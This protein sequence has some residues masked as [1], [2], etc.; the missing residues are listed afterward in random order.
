M[1]DNDDIFG[2]DSPEVPL[3]R[4]NLEK[5]KFSKGDS[6]KFSNTTFHIY[7][8]TRNYV[9]IHILKKYATAELMEFMRTRHDAVYI[10]PILEWT[11]GAH[12]TF[13]R[14]S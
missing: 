11:D 10:G 4:K 13:R 12:L 8:A 9:T 5:F 3:F 2:N 6:I 7:E 14:K 1:Q